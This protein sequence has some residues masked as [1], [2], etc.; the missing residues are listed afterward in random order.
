MY[1]RSMFLSKIKKYLTF[2][3]YENYHF[4]SRE[5]LQYIARTYLRNVMGGGERPG[6]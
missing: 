6:S 5:I 1:Q 3:S 4:Y 2:F